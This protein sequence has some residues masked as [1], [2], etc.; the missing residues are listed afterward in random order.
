[1][2]FLSKS[3]VLGR[4]DWVEILDMVR[5]SPVGWKT[6][7]WIGTIP[8]L[9]IACDIARGSQSRPWHYMWTPG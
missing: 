4:T 9:K 6:G 5:E 8:S 2:C 3:G 7:R 1:M